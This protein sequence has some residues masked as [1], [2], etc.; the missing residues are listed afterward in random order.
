MLR[1]KVN[2]EKVFQVEYFFKLM[3]RLIAPSG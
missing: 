2:E 1:P 3:Q